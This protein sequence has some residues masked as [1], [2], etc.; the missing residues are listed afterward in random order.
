MEV[1][2]VTQDDELVARFAREPDLVLSD[3]QPP[4]PHE[5]EADLADHADYEQL[6]AHPD[7]DGA[8]GSV[9]ENLEPPAPGV[10]V[11]DLDGGDALT[12][13]LND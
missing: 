1:F 4:T 5:V 8:I 6:D 12:R 3:A 7:D 10:G 13:D 9:D 11:D 2:I